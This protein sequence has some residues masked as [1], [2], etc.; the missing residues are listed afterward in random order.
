MT[1]TASNTTREAYDRLQ[2]QN[3]LLL[4]AAD[5]GD[6]D[7]VKD[8]LGEGAN[9]DARDYIGQSALHHAARSGHSEIMQY[10]ADHGANTDA[11]D[12]DGRTP[13]HVAVAGHKPDTIR[14]SIKLGVDVDKPCSHGDTPYH[15]AALT[16]NSEGAEILREHNADPSITN[17]DGWTATKLAGFMQHKETAETLQKAEQA[18][19]S[20]PPSNVRQFAPRP[21]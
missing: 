4:I 1:V 11:I 16:G 3:E 12:L 19:A 21:G 17:R 14:L 7:A 18:F 8:A 5:T 6:L 9:I 2:E 15:Y 10:L 20:R 13:L